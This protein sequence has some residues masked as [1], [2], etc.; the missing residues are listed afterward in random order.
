MLLNLWND[1]RYA[2]RRL[3][4]SPGFTAAAVATIALGVGINTGIFTVLNGLALREL[5]APEAD[6]LVDVH[7][8]IEGEGVRRFVRGARS[9]FSTSEYRAYRDG[10]RS[11]SGIMGYSVPETVTLGGDVPQEI[12]GAAVTCNYLD[13]LR[14]PS[15][16]GPGF[17]DNCDA[18]GA[19]PTIVLGHGLWTTAFGADPAIVGREVLLNRQSFT[20]VGVAPEGVRGV[21]IEPVS[22]FVP[23]STQPLLQPGWNVY[24]EEVSWLRLIGRKNSDTSLNQVRA[25]LGVIA[26]QI[27]G[28]QPPRRT[29]LIV[30]RARPLSMP[31]ARNALLAVG[32]IVMTAFGLV[33]L[34]ACANV[35][36]LLLARATGRNREI[37]V[38][39]SLGAS[40]GRLV[41]QLLAESVLI[42]V[43][44]GVLGSILA[45]WSFQGLVVLAMSALPP[46]APT[47]AIDVTPDVRVLGFALVLTL[48]SG[49]LFGLGPAVLA[50]KP[51]LHT[52]MKGDTTGRGRRSG[53]RLQGTL[54]GTQ[55]AV[56]MV[57]MV[58][59]GLLLRGFYATQT[60][61]PG[62][63]YE[64][65]AV[66]SFDLTEVGYDAA[67]AAAFQRQ[68]KERVESLPGIEAVAQVFRTPLSEGSVN[69]MARLPGQEQAFPI[70][71]NI[72]SPDYFSLVGIPIVRGRTFTDAELAAESRALIVTEATAR[73]FWPDRDPIGQ[74][75][76]MMVGTDGGSVDY[77]V[78]G[79]AKDAQITGIGEI[80]SDYVYFPAGNFA[81]GGPLSQAVLQLL[82]RSRVSFGATVAG[83]RAAAAELDP[84]LVVQVTP[85]EAN[86]EIWRSLAGLVSTLSMSLG[87]LALVLASVGVYGVVAYA[88]GR[89]VRELG[90]RIALGASARSVVALMLKRTMRPVVV[91]A[92]VGIVAAAGASRILSGVLF[93]VSPLDPVG[94]GGATLFM[95]AV[96]LTAGFLPA[97][98]A[99]R[100]DPMTT[101]RYE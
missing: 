13:V 101:L 5:P 11:L 73:R 27:D 15:V 17:G 70:V 100:V 64:N 22:F 14:Q 54:V 56:C 60:V 87:A 84:G 39:L 97:R 71:F 91:G 1:F 53:S 29:T 3:T 33:L 77:R 16:L 76:T 36:N 57:L 62:F 89:R 88:V 85:L 8:I 79:V 52:T 83:I 50:S 19:A 65:V 24:S 41:Q 98:R 34:I 21:D 18:E 81:G 90:I 26:A 6:E 55:V 43:I 46:N 99:T 92:I 51:D 68:L 58:S 25:E 49:V 75:L 63:T 10:T 45:M 40:R 69:W 7:Q 94:L 47:L 32:G 80:V 93:G 72:A 23:I 67:E 12:V 61:E 9:M 38:R 42:A 95:L 37:A 82:A 30:E 31:E 78:V 2:S 66:A 48:A 96:A 74:M 20:V 28:Q 86:L 44:G 35:A 4:K 59:T